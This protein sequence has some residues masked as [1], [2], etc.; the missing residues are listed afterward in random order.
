MLYRL[1]LDN[2]ANAVR[3][4]IQRGWIEPSPAPEQAVHPDH[5]RR[6]PTAESWR[7]LARHAH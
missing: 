2:P 4:A 3:V 5:D 1:A 7:P 6:L